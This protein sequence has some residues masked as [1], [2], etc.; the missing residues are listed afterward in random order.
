MLWLP[1]PIIRLDLIPTS[2]T[3]EEVCRGRRR[4]LPGW[5]EAA[6]PHPVSVIICTWGWEYGARVAL[7]GQEESQAK[8]TQTDWDGEYILDIACDFQPLT[9][10]PQNHTRF[11]FTWGGTFFLLNSLRQD[12]LLT[13]QNMR[14]VHNLICYYL[15]S[16]IFNFSHSPTPPHTHPT[17]SSS[18]YNTSLLDYSLM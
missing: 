7:L 11:I 4:M 13:S 17:T 3:R 18:S 14:S 5:K 1:S 6:P 2:V 15:L 10:Q 16:I 9:K 8:K 12:F